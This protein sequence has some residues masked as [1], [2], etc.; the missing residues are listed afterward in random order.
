MFRMQN[1]PKVRF[2]ERLGGNR[3]ARAT[4]SAPEPLAEEIQQLSLF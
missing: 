3:G 1:R 4:A 2:G